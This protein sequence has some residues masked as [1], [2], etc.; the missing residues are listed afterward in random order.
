MLFWILDPVANEK[1][2]LISARSSTSQVRTI[3]GDAGSKRSPLGS[4]AFR[5][6]VSYELPRDPWNAKELFSGTTVPP[7][8]P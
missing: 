5:F 4:E 7:T 2:D 8:L 1:N 3:L 6:G